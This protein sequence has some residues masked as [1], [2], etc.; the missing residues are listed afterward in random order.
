MAEIFGPDEI[1]LVLTDFVDNNILIPES[2]I[3]LPSAKER[4]Q[5]KDFD[6]YME[7]DKKY[8]ENLKNSINNYIKYENLCDTQIVDTDMV[9]K[10]YKVMNYAYCTS[11]KLIQHNNKWYNKIIILLIILIVC[12]IAWN[13]YLTMMLVK[14][15]K[16]IKEITNQNTTNIT[17]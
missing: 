7:H 14:E 2:E 17:T 1:K 10:N 3:P 15:S 5:I 11:K 13:I 8:I 6:Q 9:I 16:K 12:L 4:A